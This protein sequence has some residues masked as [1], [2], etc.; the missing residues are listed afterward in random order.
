MP[1]CCC[2]KRTKATRWK[3]CRVLWHPGITASSPP[4]DTRRTQ[5]CRAASGGGSFLTA[6]VLVNMRECKHC[7]SH[8]REECCSARAGLFV[9]EV[10]D[11][12]DVAVGGLRGLLDAVAVDVEDLERLGLA[13]RVDERLRALFRDQVV[14]HV[15]LLERGVHLHGPRH[16]LRSRHPDVVLGEVDLLEALVLL[17]R[18]RQLGCPVVLEVEA[19][20]D[21]DLRVVVAD[22]LQ[23][24]FQAAHAHSASFQRLRSIGGKDGGAC[25][26]AA[27]EHLVVV[28]V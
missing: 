10:A 27:L 25:G 13:A 4:S 21:Q 8:R 22:H 7:G 16:R 26:E 15:Q 6:A 20:R 5:H 9:E 12:L 3:C 14:A 24:L 19:P 2:R 17:E 11:S 18:I 23:R 1:E 28:H